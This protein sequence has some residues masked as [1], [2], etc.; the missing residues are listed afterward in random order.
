MPL[1]ALLCFALPVIIAISQSS[2]RALH[3]IIS[4]AMEGKFVNK[5]H[6]LF[7]FVR[8]ASTNVFWGIYDNAPFKAMQ[9]GNDQ[10]DVGIDLIV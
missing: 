8:F 10:I 4:N 5:G 7:L 6:E 1:H 3:I 2:C 9:I